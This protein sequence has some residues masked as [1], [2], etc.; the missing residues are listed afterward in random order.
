M[1]EL[2]V[3]RISLLLF[4]NSLKRQHK[5]FTNEVESNLIFNGTLNKVVTNNKGP[6]HCSNPSFTQK[7]DGNDGPLD[8]RKTNENKKDSQMG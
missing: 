4:K 6:V 2:D 7:L 1:F 5:N 3:T 8:N